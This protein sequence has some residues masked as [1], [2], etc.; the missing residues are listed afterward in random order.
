MAKNNKRNT[1]RS[2]NYFEFE[3]NKNGE[4]FMKNK[5]AKDFMY[6]AERLFREL[7][8]GKIDVVYYNEYFSDP[9]LIE[10][11]ILKADE[12]YRLHFISYMGVKNLIESNQIKRIQFDLDLYSSIAEDHRLKSE[13]YYILLSGFGDYKYN[14]ARAEYMISMVAALQPYKYN[15]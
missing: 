14:G 1:G 3:K 4:N 13:L 8:K 11:C 9:L 15:I 2:H 7:A 12:L 6:A 5:N 10:A